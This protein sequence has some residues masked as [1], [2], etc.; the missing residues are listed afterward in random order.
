MEL[1]EL[2]LENFRQFK[3][4]TIEFSQESEKG[5]TVIHGSNG[6]GKTT[7][8]NAFTWLFYEEVDFDTRPDRLVNEGAIAESSVGDRL[9]VSVRLTFEHEETEYIARR[10]AVYEKQSPTDFDGELV[11]MDLRV[12]YRDNGSWSERHNPKPTLDQIIPERLSSLFFFDGEDIEELAGIDNQSRI[13][14][15]IQNI[16][17]LTILERAT[18][19]SNAVAGRFEDEVEEHASE[20]LSKLIEE[21][22]AVEDDIEDLERKHQDVKRAR[23]R[24]DQEIRDIEQKM[25]RL[26]ESAALQQ[27]RAEYRDERDEIEAH[28]ERLNEDIRDEIQEKG[29]VTL[30]MPLIEETAQK[31]DEM[32]EDGV[33][34]SELNDSYI[35]SL[36]EAERCVCG[37]PL[38]PGTEHYRQIKAMKGD[39]VAEGVEQSALRIIGHLN[40]F[41]EMRSSF[42]EN[43]DEIIAERKGLHDEID[44]LTEKIDQV[45]SELQD[46]DLTTES[47]ESIKDLEA[48]RASKEEE[49][50]ERIAELAQLKQRIE[51]KEEQIEELQQE[52]DEQ[53]DE[54]EEAL[55][56]KRRQKAAE[57]VEEE[58]DQAFEDLKDRVRKLSNKKI[59]DTF[60]S[61]ASKD[62][63]AEI[64]ADFELKIWQRVGG[65]RVEVDKSTGER[66]IASLAFIGSL[67]AIAR[68]RY[69]ADSESEYFTGGIYPLVMDS[70]FGALDMDHRREV[71]KVI[72]ELANQ[73]VVFATDSQW[74]GPVEEEMSPVVG[75]QYW[76][77]FDDGDADDDHPVTRI[78]TERAAV[79][80]D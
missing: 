47:G 27:R 75:R 58:L 45:S 36:L 49:K 38:E 62:L 32:R 34:P 39:T 53:R 63:T 2:H 41:S 54:R 29:F 16:M 6:S 60:G 72:P 78:K 74:K 10:K 73:V 67:V 9:T 68:Q 70:P 44:N 64:T 3:D 66:Q 15:S 50:E 5:V 19:H 61:I 79:G 40:Q 13:Q 8:L 11:D 24:I 18:R 42:F 7:L 57:L 1:V 37:R 26:D 59:R 30:G 14:E 80:G 52:I 28:V 22:R 48:K 31:L 69:E 33:I 51:D 55:L 21:K 20:A 77:D 65:E 56:A 71:S 4:D 46:M 12:Q 23:D 76:L 17:G 43:V 35:D 25:E